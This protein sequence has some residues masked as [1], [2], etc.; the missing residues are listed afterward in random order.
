MAFFKRLGAFLS[1]AG[2]RQEGY[3]DGQPR[4]TSAA[5]VPVTLDTSLQLSAVWACTKLLAECVGSLP[6]KIYKLNR[7]GSRTEDKSH[8]LYK[9]MNGKPNRWQTRQEY[10]ETLV[11]QLALMGNDYTVIKR[12]SRNEIVSLIPLMSE[13]MEVRLLSDG[14]VSYRYNE[15]SNVNV[16]S[17]ETIWHNKCFG[18]GIVGLCDRDWD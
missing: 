8:P 18:N 17:S 1:G 14:T 10:F 13:Q 3:Q 4:Y 6:V 9:L 7:D 16:Y 15:G 12:N 5:A 11:W 2:Y